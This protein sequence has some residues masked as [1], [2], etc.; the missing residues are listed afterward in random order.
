MC[1]S[2]CVEKSLCIKRLCKKKKG[3]C[4]K[5]PACVLV[6]K[7]VCVCKMCVCTGMFVRK[8][9]S[10]KERLCGQATGCKSVTSSHPTSSPFFLSF[11][12]S[13][14][15]SFIQPLPCNVYLLVFFL[16]Q[17]KCFNASLQLHLNI[18][19]SCLFHLSDNF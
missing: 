6:C 5:K 11:P 15:V 9:V 12:H 13:P 19:A 14:P 7:G 18:L 10:A 17:Y 1:K 4:V 3:G 2:L 8:S 16:Y